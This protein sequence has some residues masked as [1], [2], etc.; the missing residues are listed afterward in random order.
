MLLSS[1]ASTACIY[2]L[3]I[4]P[5]ILDNFLS[6]LEVGYSKFD[7]PYH[8]LIHGADVTQTTYYLLH[9][10]KL[11][12]SSILPFLYDFLLV[13]LLYR[14]NRMTQWWNAC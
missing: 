1:T 12:V 3:Q 10:S 7:N 4:N 9:Q 14:V 5:A 11:K 6:A 13:P 8:N 2:I